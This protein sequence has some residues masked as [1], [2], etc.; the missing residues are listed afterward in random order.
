V[1]LETIREAVIATDVTDDTVRYKKNKH[2][3][4]IN[5]KA[6]QLAIS[7]VLAKINKMQCRLEKNLK[8]TCAQMANVETAVRR[9]Q[10]SDVK[11]SP[12]RAWTSANRER[13]FM[14]S[15]PEA[16][17]Q[18][19]HQASTATEILS[20]LTQR[21][22][23]YCGDVGHIQRDCVQAKRYG[24]FGSFN[25][26]QRQRT[27]ANC[28]NVVDNNNTV[29]DANVGF[30]LAIPRGSRNCLDNGHVYLVTN[31]DKQRQLAL[32]DSGCELSL[33][34]SNVVGNRVLR[35]VSKG[36]FAAHGSSILVQGKTEIKMDFGSYISTV[37]FLVSP[38]VF[39]LMLGI[40]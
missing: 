22:C 20:V 17:S 36:V 11:N 8:A 29:H 15:A 21:A 4:G 32:V 3:R 37:F 39:E 27:N 18:N 16:S 24:Y 6:E 5:T 7:S 1:R 23:Y 25:Y 30:V 35:P 26:S 40:T 28:N 2:A 34:P 14:P 12:G 38:N 19:S 13:G 10:H 9:P 33:A 31:I